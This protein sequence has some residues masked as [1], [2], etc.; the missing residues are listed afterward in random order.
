MLVIGTYCAY[1]RQHTMNYT[2]KKQTIAYKIYDKMVPSLLYYI[3][4]SQKRS[5]LYVRLQNIISL[6]PLYT[7]ANHAK[8]FENTQNE[9]IYSLLPIRGG[10]HESR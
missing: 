8:Y 7:N 4:C 3:I 6:F 2:K 9:F 1:V 5:V 10:L